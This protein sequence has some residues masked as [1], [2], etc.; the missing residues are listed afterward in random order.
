[1]MEVGGRRGRKGVAK[2]K[3]N[4]GGAEREWQRRRRAMM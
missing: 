2:K 1:M 4:D 3:D